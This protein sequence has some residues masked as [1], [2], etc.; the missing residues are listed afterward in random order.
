MP[1]FADPI[2]MQHRLF[3]SLSEMFGREVPLYDRSLLVNRV[4]NRA[5]CDLL[6]AVYGGFSVGDD[7]LDALGGERHGAIRIG[8]AAEYR[9]VSRFFACFGLEPHGFYDM[10]G[11]GPKSQPVIATAFRSPESPEHRVF[12]SLLQTD[13]FAEP[14]RGRIERAL[15]DRRVFTDRARELIETAERDGGLSGADTQALIGEATGHIF[16]WKGTARDLAL[17]N[18]LCDAGFKIAADIACFDSHHLNHLTPNTLCMDLY[19]ASMRLCMGEIGRSGFDRLARA[20]VDALI[21]DADTAWMRLHFR[22]LSRATLSGFEI[23]TVDSSRRAHAVDALAARLDGD[24]LRLSDLPHSGFKEHTEGPPAGVP[25]LLRQDA[26][27]ALTEPVLFRGVDGSTAPAEHTARFGEIEQRFY[28]T[29]PEGRALY[30][31]CLA[32]SES[33]GADRGGAFARFPSS[34]DELLARGLV[35]GRYSATQRGIDAARS[36][37]PL[38]GDDIHALIRR[39]FV[40]VEGLRYEDFL[41]FSAAGIFASNLDLH[42]TRTVYADGPARTEDDLSSVIGRPIIDPDT[43]YAGQ[44]ARSLLDTYA[45]LGM[46][47]RIGRESLDALRANATACEA[48]LQ[49]TPTA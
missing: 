45:A 9:W 8:T 19:T 22:E 23:R 30:D 37:T 25:V 27:R 32:A 21:R 42:G 41:P 26:Y 5:V 29:T 3:A 40:D 24:D 33:P 4:V 18:D 10:T 48:I 38:G 6:G 49:P 14:F 39:G 2:Q 7:R 17:Y 28:A 12:T 36:G 44:E 46:T 31:A 35:Y 13:A 43:I 34:L 16:K 15:G 11:I 1:A 47:E 20:A